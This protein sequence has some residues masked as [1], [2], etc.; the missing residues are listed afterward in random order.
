MK[1]RKFNKNQKITKLMNPRPIFSN[2][3]ENDP[4]VK[5]KLSWKNFGG[6]IEF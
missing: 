1:N 5:V 2:R 6:V 4:W 3:L